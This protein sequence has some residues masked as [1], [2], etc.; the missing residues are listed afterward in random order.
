[1]VLVHCQAGVGVPE[2]W[3]AYVVASLEV[4]CLCLDDLSSH[5]PG[6]RT[7]NV[8]VIGRRAPHFSR[9]SWQR[10]MFLNVRQT[11]VRGLT[12]FPTV[13]YKLAVSR[14]WP[15]FLHVQIIPNLLFLFLG[16]SVVERPHFLRS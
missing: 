15:H 16:Q 2:S 10:K 3:N 12:S 13:R 8:H 11:A 1:M 14:R 5:F 6:P 4:T 9:L 7:R